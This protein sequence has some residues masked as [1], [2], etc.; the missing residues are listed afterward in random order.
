MNIIITMGGLGSRFIKAGFKKPKYMVEAKGRSLFEWS[1]K[2]LTGY[3]DVI[4]KY[5][6]VVKEE[7]QSESFI[8]KKCKSLDISDYEIIKLDYLT[9]GQATTA[10]KAIPKCKDDE[11][12][13]IYNIDTYVESGVMK[14]SDI[15]GDGHIPCFH[16]PGDHWSFVRLD[17]NGRAVE[18]REKKRISDNCTLGAYYFRSAELYKNMYEEYYSNNRILDKNEKYVA[19]IYNYMINKGMEVTI[20]IVDF[21]KVHV[22]GTPEELKEFLKEK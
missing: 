4:N 20:S 2:S 16:A 22:L 15:S 6:F 21:D 1:L 3:S 5:I 13:L 12:I 7:D 8:R 11:S 19:P 18:V 14:S 9:D 17:N 10:M